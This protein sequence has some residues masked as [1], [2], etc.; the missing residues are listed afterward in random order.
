MKLSW[1]LALFFAAMLIAMPAR[2]AIAEDGSTQ[3]DAE[4]AESDAKSDE[5]NDSEGT[6]AKDD[7]ENPAEGGA[8]EKKAAPAA[9]VP[10][11]SYSEYLEK[12]ESAR[13]RHLI[14]TW[15]KHP[16]FRNVNGVYYLEFESAKPKCKGH[17][18]FF[19]D[20]LGMPS[21]VP[22]A[23]IASSAGFDAFIF[24]PM[25]D[26]S[27]TF[28]GM[29][30]GQSQAGEEFK[31]TAAAALGTIGNHKKAN[32]IIA[33]GATSGYL[34][35]LIAQTGE[36]VPNGFALVN[37]FYAND[38]ANEVL[39]SSISEFEGAVGDF[40]SARNNSWLA[41]AM[42]KRVF[43]LNKKGLPPV[44]RRIVIEPDNEMFL[45]DFATWMAK[46]DFVALKKAA[47]KLFAEMRKRKDAE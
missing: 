43:L 14:E 8:A 29:E 45:K 46:T 23:N 36:N 7:S 2:F 38:D 34:L 20:T 11:E 5:E 22:L 32:V 25:S 17:A 27:G 3:A 1:I 41:S 13:R 9:A 30:E 26:L 33:G 6:E 12:K 47:K 31:A 42:S 21:M 28:P 35:E 44:F 15:S 16:H 37:G 10:Q 39:A 18:F 19:P 24:L 4:A 40:S